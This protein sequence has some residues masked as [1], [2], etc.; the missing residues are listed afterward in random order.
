M[1]ESLIWFL[2]FVKYFFLKKGALIELVG[3]DGSGKTSLSELLV[4]K[5]YFMQKV[6]I[7]M[8]GFPFFQ[9]YLI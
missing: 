7:F 4:E 5:N 9:E 2:M 3:P 1:K 8:V 6:N